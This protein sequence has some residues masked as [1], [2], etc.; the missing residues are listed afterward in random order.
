MNVDLPKWEEL[1]LV[2]PEIW[3]TLT[4]CAVVIVPFIRRRGIVLPVVTA[5][6]GLVL[7][8]VSALPL[9]PQYI[10]VGAG[11]L[12]F[13]GALAI[14]PFSQF[15]KV[16]LLVFVVFIVIQWLMTSRHETDDRDA[17]DF[18]CLLLGATLG[19][20]LMASATNLL[21]I[22]VAM[23]TASLPSFALA[24]FAKHR[25]RSTEGSL[26]YVLFGAAASAVGLYGM[27]LLYGAAG[28]LD[29]GTIAA[30]AADG[31]M[32]PMFAFGLTAMF[33]GIAFKLSAVPLHFWC[34]DVFEGAPIEV[35]TFLSVASKGA[36]LCLLLRVVS[37]FGAAETQVGLT[38]GIAILGAVTATWGNLVAL[39]Q[40][41]IKRLLAYSSIAHAGYLIMAASLTGLGSD[42]T[43]AG[44]VLFYLFVYMFM[45]LGAFTVAALV[46]GHIGSEDI[47][48][49]PGLLRRNVW[50]T[51]LL[52]IFLL[53]LLGMPPLGGFWAKV[54]LGIAMFN[55]GNEIAF[56]LIIVLF[57]NT[58]ISLYFY[59]RPV[60][61]M[62]FVSEDGSSAAF[63]PR[64]AGM[65]LVTFCAV[66]LLWTGLLPGRASKLAHD[67][68]TITVEQVQRH[69]PTAAVPQPADRE[70]SDHGGS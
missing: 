50:L 70:G 38:T 64:V 25:R 17:P 51:V 56:L 1:R 69:Q 27:S 55:T 21:T 24:G 44:A 42:S 47:R 18:L 11:T 52:S 12:V 61:Y 8:L 67:Y 20:A 5:L 41:N 54:F 34:P 30:R 40:T 23:E 29:L 26:K 2:G 9:G 3:L 43:V 14:D 59:V 68:G 62:V 66:I 53:S 32:T 16:L 36:G 49:F 37:A 6:I 39:H 22:F 35:T 58:L 57:T 63:S 13:S 45:N 33:A 28:S 15:F 10:N 19:M 4:M 46:S 31:G 7:A 65:A 60:Y 48:D